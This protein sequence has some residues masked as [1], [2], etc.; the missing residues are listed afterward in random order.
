MSFARLAYS[1]LVYALTPAALVRLWWRGRRESGYREHV[2]ERFGFYA[3]APDARASIWLHAVSV[4]ETRAAEPLVRALLAHFPAQ[5]ILMTHM[6]PTGRRTGAALFGDHVARAYLPYDSPAAVARFLRHFRPRAGILLETEI[7]PNLIR[8]CRTSRVPLYLVNARL[9]E[10]SQRRYARFAPLLEESLRSLDAIA[11]QTP[12]DAVRLRA[13]GAANVHVTGNL[14]FDVVPAPAQLELGRAWRATYGVRPVLLAA[15]TRDGE[16]TLLLDA[17]RTLPQ[18]VLLVVGPRH[19]QRFEEGA[20]LLE[21]RGIDFR[22]RSMGE[23]PAPATR[24]LLGDS[25]GELTAYYAAC[26]IAFIGGSLLAY[27]GQNLIEACAAGKPVLVG[28]HTY[29][30]A[31]AAEQ[32]IAAGAALRV[33]DVHELSRVAT[34]LLADSATLHRMGDSGVAFTRQHQGATER[35][36]K[37]LSPILPIDPATDSQRPDRPA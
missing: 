36:M 31:E 8:A 37:L 15:S 18:D 30:F 10:K 25:M 28:P 17:L 16:E 9:S 33:G 3:A 12:A 1:V 14:K 22:R 27:G 24:V 23:A 20:A 35:V 32:A 6:T 7:W 4:G 26:D 13:L 11:A 19:P 29:N 5:V 2:R 34:R 21:R